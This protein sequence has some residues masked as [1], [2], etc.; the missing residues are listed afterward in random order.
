MTVGYKY[1]EFVN[2]PTI[3]QGELWASTAQLAMEMPEAR[4]NQIDPYSRINYL[5]R[6]EHEGYGKYAVE[7]EILRKLRVRFHD[8]VRNQVVVIENFSLYLALDESHLLAATKDDVCNDFLQRI[9]QQH[10]GFSF[11]SR[12]VDLVRMRQDLQMRVNGGYFSKLKIADVKAA[13]IFGPNVSESMDWDRYEKSG[14]ISALT[15]DLAWEGMNL[16]VQVT[17]SGGVVVYDPLRE[18][19]QLELVRVVNGMVAPYAETP[20]RNW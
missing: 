13:A 16:S 20:K 17:K 7:H 15:L 6:S 3:V 2:M 12:V 5:G 4:D 11:A 8:Q 19:D 10:V 18:K 1:R 9:Q 14:E